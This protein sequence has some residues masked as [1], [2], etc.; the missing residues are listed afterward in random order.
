MFTLEK[1]KKEEKKKGKKEKNEEKRKGKK[2]MIKRKRKKQI[3][4]NR[5]GGG[6]SEKG[7]KR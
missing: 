1:E 2:R 7:G 6:G 5:K 3:K 4:V